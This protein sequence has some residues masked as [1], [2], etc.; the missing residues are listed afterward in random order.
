VG[1]P[2][3]AIY[4]HFLMEVDSGIRKPLKCTYHCIKSCDPKTTS[5]CIFDALLS[6]CHGNLANGFAFTGSNVGKVKN[7]STVPEVF[8]QLISEYEKAESEF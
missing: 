1:M 2:G 5:Y 7:I 4:N 8:H 3:R 6:A